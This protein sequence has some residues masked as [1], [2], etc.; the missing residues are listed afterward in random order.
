MSYDQTGSNAPVIQMTKDLGI[1]K[2]IAG[3][4]AVIHAHVQKLAEAIKNDS[5]CLKYNPILV[6]EKFQVIDGQH[7]LQATIELGTPIYYMQVPGLKLRNAQNLNKLSKPWNPEDYARSYAELGNEHYAKYLEFKEKYGYNHDILLKYL[8]L[9]DLVS[10]EMFR[11]GK[12]K[13][14]NE[15]KSHD[16]CSKLG[17]FEEFL[18]K[19]QTKQRPF[20]LAF[21]A[22]WEIKRYN[23]A[24]MLRKLRSPKN[25]FELR[26][27]PE[28]YMRDFERIYNKNLEPGK[29]IR[30]F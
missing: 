8:S 9:E 13:V 26:A 28:D 18:G 14:T 11:G 5:D 19:R 7:R 15:K 10:M 2:R 30:C 6:N 21:R 22:V 17:D 16:L 3:N 4:R 23:H 24:E 29:R 20:A 25:A 27:V 1:F 12:F